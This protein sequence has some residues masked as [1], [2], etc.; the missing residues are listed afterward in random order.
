MCRYLADFLKTKPDEICNHLSEKAS[1]GRLFGP[2]KP[3]NHSN[4]GKGKEKKKERRGGKEVKRKNNGCTLSF[5][6]RFFADCFWP[7]KTV[8]RKR[9]I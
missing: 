8:G 1:E 5:Y 3:Q 2:D 4:Q 7:K 9:S 6:N